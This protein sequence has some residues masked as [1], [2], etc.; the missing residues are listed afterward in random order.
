M[1]NPKLIELSKEQIYERFQGTDHLWRL[2]DIVLLAFGYEYQDFDWSSAKGFPRRQYDTAKEAIKSDK[3]D[4]VDSKMEADG[5]TTYYVKRS[6]FFKWLRKQ[7]AWETGVKKTLSQWARFKSAQKDM[8]LVP[9][10]PQAKAS[11]YM[12]ELQV[13]AY[14]EH[15]K[16][17]PKKKFKANMS[18]WSK[19]VC[20]AHPELD[21]V[22]SSIKKYSTRLSELE[23]L[24]RLAEPED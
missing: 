2:Q 12:D 17:T 22:A 11:G 13:T 20:K 10:E 19:Q 21:L 16:S 9:S 7:K 1:S 24:K 23:L 18:A 4:E 6:T 14:R 5:L 8:S 15:L 3:L